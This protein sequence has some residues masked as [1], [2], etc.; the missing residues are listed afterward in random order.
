MKIYFT[1][2][3]IPQLQNKGIKERFALIEQ[4]QHKLSAPEKVLLNIL[5]LCIIIPTFV[6]ILKISQDWL[7]ILWAGAFLLCY[8]LILRPV[9]LT[10][11]S[12]KI[13]SKN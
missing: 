2:R 5:K 4:A 10:L 7:A 11:L 8:P 1:S 12:R 9:H 6:F 13:P 3:Q